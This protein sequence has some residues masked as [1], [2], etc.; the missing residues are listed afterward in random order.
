MNDAT[1]RLRSAARRLAGIA[2]RSAGSP[3]ESALVVL[4]PEAEST[5]RDLRAE[6]DPGHA[7][8]AH[9]TVLYPF[10]PVGVLDSA[11]SSALSTIFASVDAFDF[12]LAEMKW[13]GDR[14]AYVAPRP[15][16][17][18]REMTT[19]VVKRFPQYPPYGGAFAEIVPHLC[20]AEDAPIDRMRSAA[21]S[22]AADLP[23]PAR[24]AHVHLMGYRAARGTWQV[25]EKFALRSTS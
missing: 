11:V 15:D 22:V 8:P 7:M 24:A 17:S 21:E 19:G 5:V 13:F 23:I 2:R 16:S 18:F 10:A 9:I 3:A 1:H 20:V 25:L 6:L 12:E 4:V 14:V